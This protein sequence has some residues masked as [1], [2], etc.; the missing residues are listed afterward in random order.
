M[1]M[2][3]FNFFAMHCDDQFHIKRAQTDFFVFFPLLPYPV[4]ACIW[5]TSGSS[6]ALILMP[7]YFSILVPWLDALLLEYL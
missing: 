2:F 4:A 1:S 5:S 7:H 3:F 6:R